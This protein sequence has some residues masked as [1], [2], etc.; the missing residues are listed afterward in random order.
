[1]RIRLHAEHL[2]PIAAPP[3]AGGWVELEHGRV[4]RTGGRPHADGPVDA[5]VDLGPVVVMPGLVNAHVH[6]ELSHLRGRVPPADAFVAWVTTMLRTRRDVP[7]A[8]GE[9]IA[10]AV[11]EAHRSGTVAFGD[12]GNT[13]A[14]VAPL[15]ASGLDAWH[16]HEMIGFRG[17]TGAARAEAAWHDVGRS[18]QPAGQGHLRRGVAPHAPYSTAPDLIAGITRGL[19]A[20]QT[21]RSSIH[22][23]EGVEELQL[24]RD[25][26]GPWRELLERFGTWDP[27]WTVP[28]A[29]PVTY[30]ERIDALHPHLLVVHGTQVTRAG[31]ARLA[32]AGTTLVVCAR[33]NAWV[34]VGAPPV[35]EALAAGVRLA[36]GT[37]SLASVPDLDM[38]AE[39]AALARL[40]PEVPASVLLRAA[41]LG[42]AQALGLEHLG[43]V[44]PGTSARLLVVAVPAGVG[45]VERWLVSGEVQPAHVRWLPD[46]LH[47]AGIGEE[48]CA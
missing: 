12:I 21:R 15:A 44:V 23:A 24:L 19:D 36:V 11:D 16:F 41:T 26:S 33:S 13:D 8:D 38:F 1:M 45:D 2:L 40:A 37:D 4:V 6:L 5:E 43:A 47:E 42:G 31:L 20:D 39:L 28:H 29:D 32:R 22:L 25:G 48:W 9:V 27:D 10:A 7:A 3:L 30:L 46:C 34:G 14:A 17:G 18:D 35:A